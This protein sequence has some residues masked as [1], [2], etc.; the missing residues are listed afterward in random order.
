MP[1]KSQMRDSPVTVEDTTIR[2]ETCSQDGGI[3]SMIYGM[4][5]LTL[6]QLGAITSD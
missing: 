5:E 4:P 3:F 6:G 2:N 1:W